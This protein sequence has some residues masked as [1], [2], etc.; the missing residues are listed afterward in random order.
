MDGNG[1]QVNTVGDTNLTA[2]LPDWSMAHPVR[3]PL[4]SGCAICGSSPTSSQEICELIGHSGRSSV[5]KVFFSA[6]SFTIKFV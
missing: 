3:L 5:L 2:P 6:G 4:V 1:I